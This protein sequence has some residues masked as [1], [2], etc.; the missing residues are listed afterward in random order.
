MLAS[1]LIV[2]FNQQ[3]VTYCSYDF[4]DQ[5]RYF[6]VQLIDRNAGIAYFTTNG[7]KDNIDYGGKN[8]LIF[9]PVFGEQINV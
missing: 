7:M 1:A 9:E 8:L 4:L 2:S 3:R 6:S 5:S